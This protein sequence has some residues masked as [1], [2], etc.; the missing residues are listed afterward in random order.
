[1]DKGTLVLF[2][3]LDPL[4]Q[5]IPSILEAHRCQLIP[6]APV[7]L[8][9][10]SDLELLEP[11]ISHAYKVVGHKHNFVSDVFRCIWLYL[12]A[13]QPTSLVC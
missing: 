6:E 7:Y 8:A 12:G 9:V 13:K 1:M 4:T 11:L 5:Q 10:P 2:P 3:P